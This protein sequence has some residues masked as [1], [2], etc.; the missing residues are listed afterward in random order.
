MHLLRAMDRLD[1]RRDC[2]GHRPVNRAAVRGAGGNLARCKRGRA[3]LPLAAAFLAAILCC[4]CSSSSYV[5]LRG[6]PLNPLTPTLGLGTWKGAKP[7]GGTEQFLRRYDL[8]FD[9][10]ADPRG[11]LL[12][13][14]NVLNR[15]PTHDGLYAAAE[16]AYI[17]GLKLQADKN[18]DDA[19]RLYGAAVAHAYL[20]LL[21]PRFAE[22]R[23]AFDPQFR[24]G[25]DIYNASLEAVLRILRD[26]GGLHP[27]ATYTI[28]S[29]GQ[30]WDINV[31]V[32]ESLWHDADVGR[33][34]FVSDYAITGLQNTYHTYGLG[35]P[36]IV[37]R[38]NH[39][40]LDPADKYYAPGLAFPM[41][42]F[43]RLLPDTSPAAGGHHQAV[44][45][46]HDPLTA[47][48]VGVD[49]LRVP[50]ETDLS[51]PLAYC[52]DDPA[53]Q[54]L[55]QPTLGLLRPNST[56]TLTGL[57]MLEPYQ[58]NKIP[59]LMI[60]GLWSSPVTWME[61]FNELQASRELR[62]NYQFWFYVYPTGQPF[63]QSA[64]QLRQDLAAT[65]RD[66]RSGAS[67]G[68]PG[69]DGAGRPQHGRANCPAA[70]AR[71]RQRFLETGEHR[72]AAAAEGRSDRA[73][74]TCRHLFLRAESGDPPRDYHRHAVPRLERL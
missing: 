21:D 44:I 38:N 70:N 53:F 60:H 20:C 9:P 64:A 63:W 66:A 18:L 16:L 15:E 72:A 22:G 14:Q 25:C 4:G 69:S 49:E 23:N 62:E 74:H 39:Q 67:L 61:M 71:Q 1:S 46:L 41:T 7:S 40:R 11:L 37:V 3:M 28:E 59:V 5:A 54:K 13:V 43:V 31:A 34:E 35:V 47:T 52:L 12:S 24:Q 32:R 55:D 50:L 58:P 6:S 27:G 42:A 48:E 29:C 73:Q 45:E 68:G 65:P 33:I 56:A 26:Q 19:R 2:L 51:T 57:Y 30:T 8:A 10:K 17:G 36:L